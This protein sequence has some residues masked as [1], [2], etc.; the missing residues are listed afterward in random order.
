MTIVASCFVLAAALV[1]ARAVAPT[2]WATIFTIAFDS[3]I[4]S[5][6]TRSSATPVEGKMLYDWTQQMQRVDHGAGAYECVVFY[7]SDLPCSL[8][9]TPTGMYR[10]LSEPLPAGQE[11]CCLDLDFIH[12]SA[13]TWAVDAQPTFVG[14]VRDEYSQLIGNKFKFDYNGTVEDSSCHYYTELAEGGKMQ[15]SPLVFTFPVDDGRQDYRFKVGSYEGRH[16][17]LPATLFALPD[18]CEKTMCSSST[19]SK[20]A[21]LK[22]PYASL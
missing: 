2:P 15:G 13:P 11:Q 21:L 4:T 12:A 10:T 19:K 17:P 9:F 20:R 5:A 1:S 22:K 16:Q 8:Y 7:S 3:N 14:A 6:G 18:G